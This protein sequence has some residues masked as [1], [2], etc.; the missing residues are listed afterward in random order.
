[1]P[2]SKEVALVEDHDVDVGVGGGLRERRTL[3]RQQRHCFSR[4]HAKARSY[5]R[6]GPVTT[7]H[8]HVVDILDT[9][10]ASDDRYHRPHHILLVTEAYKSPYQ[11]HVATTS[12]VARLPQRAAWLVHFQAESF[13][14]HRTTSP[15]SH[16]ATIHSKQHI[17]PCNFSAF[18]G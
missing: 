10:G 4:P 14:C 11:T 7:A 8:I 3:R 12:K 18:Y 1:M 13:Y 17:L 2:W 9:G 5:R 15:S 16:R 6:N